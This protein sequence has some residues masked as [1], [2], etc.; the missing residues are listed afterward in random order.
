M[1]QTP[2]P[3][4]EIV[5]AP[6]RGWDFVAWRDLYAYHDLLWLLV[7][8]DFATRYKQT[9]LG[10]LWHVFQ[11]LLTTVLFTI[12]FSQVAELP[13]DGLP[14]SL[15]YLSGL[16]AWSYFSQPFNSTSATLTANAGL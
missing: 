1:N 6:T 16:L 5:I 11:P 14:P 12:V 3:F 15:F 2:P 9:I 7:W 8:R 13:T 10:P 4:R